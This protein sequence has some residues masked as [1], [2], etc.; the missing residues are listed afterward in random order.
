[1]NCNGFQNSN[2]LRI[3]AVGEWCEGITEGEPEA[4][5]ANGGAQSSCVDA[6]GCSSKSLSGVQYPKS[7]RDNPLI[8]SAKEQIASAE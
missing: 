4:E 3:E 7:F 8:Q 5:R 6:L 1:V 2:K